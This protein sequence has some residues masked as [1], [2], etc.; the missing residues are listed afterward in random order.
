MPF[1]TPPHPT[2]FLTLL[3][4]AC[5]T[6]RVLGEWWFDRCDRLSARCSQQRAR[7]CRP[8]AGVSSSAMAAAATIV[9]QVWNPHVPPQGHID[10]QHQWSRVV[11]RVIDHDRAHSARW[12]ASPFW[13]C[14]QSVGLDSQNDLPPSLIPVRRCRTKE[15]GSSRW[16]SVTYTTKPKL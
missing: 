5:P 7:S 9:R 15:M 2:S 12:A 1:P 11:V 13:Q 14:C 16:P 8:P 4:R 10:L 6:Q 3:F